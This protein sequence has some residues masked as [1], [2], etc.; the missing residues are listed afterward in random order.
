MKKAT[1][2]DKNGNRTGEIELPEIAFG[3]DPNK[4]VLWQY[5][6]THNA[7]QRTGT[8]SAKTRGDLDFGGKKPY[9]QK[10]TGHARQGTT[11]S[12][13]HV[14]G[15]VAFPPKPREYRMKFPLK[16]RKLALA[17]ILSDRALSNTVFVFDGFDVPELKTKRVLE[18]LSKAQIDIS[19]KTIIIT[20]KSNAII[21]K[22]ARNID[23][24]CVTHSGEISAYQIINSHNVIVEKTA[25]AKLEEMCTI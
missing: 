18:I 5:V 22:S 8:H 20:D 4:H 17:S 16:M 9:R 24:V 14:G 21:Y 15:G 13:V 23:N 10:G 12:P 6:V 7:N 25:L 1:L 19:Q 3:I 11:T 2:F